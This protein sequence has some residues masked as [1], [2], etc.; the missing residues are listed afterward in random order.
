MTDDRGRGLFATKD[1]NKG[2]LIV[3]DVAV[4]SA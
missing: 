3:V 4:D 2:E 1:I